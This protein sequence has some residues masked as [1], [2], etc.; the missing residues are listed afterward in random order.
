MKCQLESAK[1]FIIN[2]AARPTPVGSA[3]LWLLHHWSQMAHNWTDMA[4]TIGKTGGRGGDGGDGGYRREC[5]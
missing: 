4:G 5:V 1:V 2:P 3:G